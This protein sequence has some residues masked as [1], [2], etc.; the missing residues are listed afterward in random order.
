MLLTLQFLNS[1]SII[2]KSSGT[3]NLPNLQLLEHLDLV[4]SFL[5]NLDAPGFERPT[6]LIH[7]PPFTLNIVGFGYPSQG[8]VTNRFCNNSAGSRTHKARLNTSNDIPKIPD[9]SITGLSN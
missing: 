7:P 8:V 5:Q 3:L 4:Q 6:A 1:F 2:S 9:A